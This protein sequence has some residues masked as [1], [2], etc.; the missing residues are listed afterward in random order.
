MT[1]TTQTL[2]LQLVVNEDA[3][4]VRF[5]FHHTLLD[6]HGGAIR[7]DAKDAKH[8]D[9]LSAG[10]AW[11]HFAIADAIADNPENITHDH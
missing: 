11:F 7:F 1:N 8:L 3:D 4:E 9:N 2:T 6:E 10:M 5:K